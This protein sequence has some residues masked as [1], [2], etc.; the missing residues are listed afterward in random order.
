M[1][2][3]ERR[4]L[5]SLTFNLAP[6]PDDVWKPSPYHVPELHQDVVASI[7]DGVDLARSST[8]GCPLG[9][10]VE[11]PSGVGKT[12]LLGMVRERTQDEGG[13]FFLV[14][15][16]SGATF[17]PSVAL[18]VV[19]GLKKPGK[20]WSSQLHTFLRRLTS[21]IG[22]T[23]TQRDAICGDAPL[24]VADL[25]QFIF[26][27]R[28][29]DREG[30]QET[31]HTARALVLLASKNFTNEDI[32]DAYLS[33]HD[34]NEW[35]ER[36][37]WGITSAVRSP[38]LVVRDISRLLAI[39]GPTVIALDQID[40][41][42]AQSVNS[43]ISTSA[44]SLPEQAALIGQVADGLMGIRETTRRTLMV[45]SCLPD[46]W[47]ILQKEAA[48]PLPDRFRPGVPAA[49]RIPS[50]EVGL[51]IVRKRLAYHYAEV[52]FKPDY[53]TWP[54]K[55]EAFKDAR[56][57]SAR[58]LLRRVD[59]HVSSCLRA[60]A[61]RELHSLDDD[62]GTT[63]IPP[64]SGTDTSPIDRRFAELLASADI[65]GAL[66]PETEDK[67]LP[68]L[69]AA[70]LSAWMIEQR[71]EK[72]TYKLDPPPNSAPPL[73][74]RLRLILDESREDEQHWAFRGI[75]APHPRSVQAR[76]QKACLAAGLTHD[77][78]KRRVILLRNATWDLG[79]KTRELVAE[80]RSQGGLTLTITEDDLKVFAALRKLLAEG[81]DGLPEWL[82]E[83][84]LAGSTHLLREALAD[85]PAGQTP[86]ELVDDALPRTAEGPVPAATARIPQQRG[87]TMAE[88]E[89]DRYIR[90]GVGM[91]DGA[92]LVVDLE[93]L[94]K[95]T[96]IF[97]GSGS[98]KTVLI[99]RL[100][101]ECA[102]SGVSSIVLDPNNDLARLGDPWPEPPAGWGPDDAARSAEYLAN[103]DVVVWT[104]RI[105]RG[106]PLTFQPLPS[107]S[108]VRH[109]PDE[110]RAAIDIA[111]A[112]LAPRAKMDGDTA[113]AVRG[114]AVL[115]AALRSFAKR[116]EST[117]IGSFIDILAELPEGI[118]DLPSGPKLA[119]EMAETLS[120]VRENDPLFG[121]GGEPADPSLLLT[122]PAGKRARVSVISFVGLHSDEHRQAFVNQLQMALFAWIK[123]NPA[124]DRP[125]GGLFVMDEAQTFAP[126]T[127]NTPCT[128]STLQLT[129]Q[130]RKY[131]LGLVFATQ[132]PKGLHNRIPGN[133]T[134]QFFG[135]LNANVQIAAAREMAQ[136]K[137]SALP[138]IGLLEKGQFYATGE[139]RGFQKV[140]TPLCLSHHPSS[141]LTPEQVIERAAIS[142]G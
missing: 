39:T 94:R 51:D 142:V 139:G 6:V 62:E 1:N 77:V 50:A 127:G 36:A 23:T 37:T 7:F 35:P 87:K 47:R 42:F 121:G 88:Q 114:Q 117:D 109:D 3:A 108:A 41:L 118:T 10:V 93:S 71:G 98:G 28:T 38:Q 130:A 110:L 95:H 33:S 40:T 99:R 69:L 102:L 14:S 134:T 78:P 76:I 18:A 16:L 132:A 73:H 67:A 5:A 116:S 96:A 91:D 131:G 20:G 27:L 85:Q 101:E 86:T 55:A 31:Q 72:A 17:W 75:S 68:P 59:Q 70:G 97:A 106:R 57:Y 65:S 60:N 54:I 45:V 48:T 30:G 8:D 15:L 137:G 119:R 129:S 111:V 81:A 138:D 53:P 89:P 12:H 126:S 128:E 9:V 44:S 25:D 43:V 120:A 29:Y 115:R 133:A 122:P 58:A 123:R 52:N 135:L 79:P 56:N 24:T 83:K 4:A 140:K 112:A 46:T 92:P 80:F 61:V 105:G 26:A 113:K 32:A 136:T 84:Q 100:I 22:M 13:Y 49:G 19:E 63:S 90:L 11:G 124:G 141:P 34:G 64:V 2:P 21:T 125:L 74:A 104:P 103:T 82:E 66:A 107:F